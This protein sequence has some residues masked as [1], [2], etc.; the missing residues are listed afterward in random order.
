MTSQPTRVFAMF[1]RAPATPSARATPSVRAKPRIRFA[2]VITNVAKAK[3]VDT[4]RARHFREGKKSEKVTSGAGTQRGGK[5]SSKTTRSQRTNKAYKTYISGRPSVDDVDR[6]SRGDKTK[7]MGVVEREAPYRLTRDERQ[8][9]ERAKKRGNVNGFVNGTGG[10]GVLEMQS[11]QSC[12][13]APHRHP[14]INTHRLWCDA[15]SAAF[16][17]IEQDQVTGADEIVVDLSTL[18]LDADWA[19]R[20]MLVELARELGGDAVHVEDGCADEEPLEAQMRYIEVTERGLLTAD[21]VSTTADDDDIDVSVKPPPVEAIAEAEAAI[22]VAAER[23]R[24]LKDSGATNADDAVKAS[25]QTLLELKTSLVTLQDAAAAAA[26]PED[27]SNT[28]DAAVKGAEDIDADAVDVESN[29]ARIAEE[30]RKS[31][32]ELP[33]HG[34]P[35]RFIRFKCPDRPTAKSL[36]KAF[37]DADLVQRQLGQNAS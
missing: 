13:L 1:A 32:A 4:G 21:S 35:E 6:A 29:T 20:E 12:A 5:G 27:A 26:A 14:L 8:A 19:C 7:V 11:K 15:K 34:L 24:A 31:L 10:G 9:W 28:I 2:L 17:V 33:I 30:A 25:V 18:R 3:N 36:A 23:V 16:I 22:A 37:A